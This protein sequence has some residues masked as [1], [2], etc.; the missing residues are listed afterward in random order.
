MGT[1]DKHRL[2]LLLR[3]LRL[4]GISHNAL[5]IFDDG[6]SLSLCRRSTT[7][8]KGNQYNYLYIK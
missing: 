6:Y 2:H 1:K 3:Q 7:V 8:Y 4:E 5:N